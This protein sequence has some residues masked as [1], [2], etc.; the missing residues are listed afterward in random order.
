MTIWCIYILFYCWCHTSSKITAVPF[1]HLTKFWLFED[2]N[3]NVLSGMQFLCLAPFPRRTAGPLTKSWPTISIRPANQV[4]NAG[5]IFNIF[6]LVTPS[7]VGCLMISFTIFCYS[8]T[9]ATK[10]MLS[11]ILYHLNS[12]AQ[13]SKFVTKVSISLNYKN[14]FQNLTVF[15]KWAKKTSDA[16]NYTDNNASKCS[17]GSFKL[18]E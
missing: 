2:D 17:D 10:L 12:L 11:I 14:I 8:K 6:H 13:P 7:F 5:N 15:S 9:K 18:T 16:L 3:F 1:A 4:L